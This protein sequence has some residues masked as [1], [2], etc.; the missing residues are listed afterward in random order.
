M[1]QGQNAYLN[2]GEGLNGDKKIESI[3]EYFRDKDLRQEFYKYF[4]E[5]EEVYE[6]LSPDAFLRPFMRDYDQ[7]VQMYRLVRSA[8]EPG[9][10]SG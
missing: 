1:E 9:G 6:I 8:Y 3:L 5:L 10:P 4:R 2:I 7:L